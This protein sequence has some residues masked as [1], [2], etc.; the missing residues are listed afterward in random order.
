MNYCPHCGAKVEHEGKFC[1]TC[2]KTLVVETAGNTTF[3]QSF[4][5]LKQ[6]VP[7]RTNFNR[8]IKFMHTNFFLIHTIYLAIFI[9]TLIS[10]WSGLWALILAAIGIYLYGALHSSDELDLNKQVK[11]M[12][13]AVG[14]NR[15]IDT[16]KD[17][18]ASSQPTVNEN[19]APEAEV[20]TKVPNTTEDAFDQLDVAA[21]VVV[22]P[23]TF[24]PTIALEKDIEPTGDATKTAPNDPELLEISEGDVEAQTAVATVNS[25]NPS[26]PTF[27]EE[28]ATR[29]S[30]LEREEELDE[31]EALNDLE[32]LEDQEALNELEQLEDQAAL[33]ELERL[34]D[35]AALDELE[36]NELEQL[37][38]GDVIVAPEG[39]AEI[40]LNDP[41]EKH[42]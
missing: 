35:Q 22:A 40:Q 8:V 38:D 1:Q 7:N 31:L 12:I 29:D 26:T 24:E 19:V 17:A 9:I 37:E 14:E 6:L 15:P 30:L 32:Q 5:Q 3:K 28:A 34:E 2:G 33:N 39:E 16:K 23:E 18:M 36:P 42:F 10:P 27:G 11:E 20:Y 4:S 25:L 41:E 13:M 21:S